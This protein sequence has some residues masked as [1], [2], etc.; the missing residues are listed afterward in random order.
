MMF[1]ISHEESQASRYS[2][3]ASMLNTLKY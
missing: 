1:V 2:S 3:F